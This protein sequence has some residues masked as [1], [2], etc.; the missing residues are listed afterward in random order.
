MLEGPQFLTECLSTAQM[1]RRMVESRL[2]HA[3]AGG[4]NA[5]TPVGQGRQRHAQPLIGLAD[6][7][8]KRHLHIAE[9]H[10]GR[11]LSPVAHFSVGLADSNTRLVGLNHQLDHAVLLAAAEHD[12][13]VGNRR[14]GDEALL[15]VDDVAITLSTRDGRDGLRR[16]IRAS[17]WLGGGKG[18]DLGAGDD[19]PQ[20]AL[21]DEV[22][23][24][25]QRP[26]S[27]N[28]VHVEDSR[29]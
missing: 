27:Q 4:G 13:E 26:T 29:N 3:D 20:V 23:A 1:R 10:I 12:D 7:A 6:P 19:R 17:Q 24:S 25:F 15:S 14:V 16:Q 28:A 21:T 11:Q 18:A 2:R 22:T 5:D 8:L 9:M